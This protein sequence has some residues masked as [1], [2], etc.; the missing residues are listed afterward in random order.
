MREVSIRTVQGV[1]DIFW[2]YQKLAPH[3][4]VIDIEILLTQDNPVSRRAL[5]FV[6]LLPKVRNVTFAQVGRQYHEIC[7]CK[8]GLQLVFDHPGVRHNYAINAWLEAGTRL[9]AIEPHLAVQWGVQ[10]DGVSETP[11]SRDF[12]AVY[13]SG[14]KHDTSWSVERWLDFLVGLDGIDDRMSGPLVLL[15]APY[16]AQPLHELGDLLKSRAGRSVHYRISTDPIEAIEMLR[17]ARLFVGY[18]SG[19]NV[20]ADNYDT[21]QVMLY[22]PYLKAMMN[23]WCKPGHVESGLFRAFTFDQ[24]NESILHEC[25]AGL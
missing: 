5:P 11:P 15:G 20:I 16:D 4:D 10:F 12:T 17:N 19:L 25:Q 6:Q 7:Q 23:S 18:Q 3:F 14:N 22:F 2:V 8:H 1:G 24:S 13:V 21:P 9:E